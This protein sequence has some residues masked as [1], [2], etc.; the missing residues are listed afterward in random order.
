ML[1]KNIKRSRLIHNFRDFKKIGK[2]YIVRRIKRNNKEDI[3]NV[4]DIICNKIVKIQ[5]HIRGYLCRKHY[6]YL[7]SS[8]KFPIDMYL[9][10]T[11]ILG[12][13]INEI[14]DEYFI[15]I[16]SHVLHKYYYF[17]IRELNNMIAYKNNIND[18]Y[19]DETESDTDSDDND[20]TSSTNVTNYITLNGRYVSRNTDSNDVLYK[21][22][23][24]IKNPYDNT[25]FDIINVN[26]IIYRIDILKKNNKSLSIENIIPPE[27]ILTAKITDI[28]TILSDNY[29]YP[30]INL[31]YN[32]DMIDFINI[33]DMILKY[34]AI[35]YFIKTHDIIYLHNM[36]HNENLSLSEC[37]VNIRLKVIDIL[38]YL[39]KIN[40]MYKENRI[41]I[42]YNAIQ[43]N[44]EHDF[45]Q[46]SSIVNYDFYVI[47][48]S[49][50]NT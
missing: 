13:S 7:L 20:T 6:K 30:D 24:M 40:D 49:I 34:S 23:M 37:E 35:R 44:D 25:Y 12:N 38:I 42:I 14:E 48:N 18:D 27:S 11:S 28:F 45:V 32:F 9:N 10:D 26:N 3:E 8:H 5:S 33:I 21:T 17:D 31:F 43:Y 19:G 36:Y 2:K 4:C 50:T 16:R 15:N 41:L 22:N 1:Y 29:F 46:D 47:I 39:L